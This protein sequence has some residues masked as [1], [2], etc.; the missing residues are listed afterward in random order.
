MPTRAPSDISPR[1]AWE[2]L[3]AYCTGQE[4][5]ATAALDQIGAHLADPATRSDRTTTMVID[6]VFYAV[7]V[8]RQD[9]VFHGRNPYARYN[10]ITAPG[11]HRR[12][13]SAYAAAEGILGTALNQGDA[14]P[15]IRAWVVACTPATVV[16]LVAETAG[17][18]AMVHEEHAR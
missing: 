3:A 11:R 8:L 2:L 1:L 7:G 12:S 16:D 6:L 10:L 15:L 5:A 13:E 4:V 9:A 18:V 17:I 14:R